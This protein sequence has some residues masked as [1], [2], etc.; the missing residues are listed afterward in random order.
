MDNY[1]VY[2]NN[3]IVAEFLNHKGL[4]IEVKWVASSAT[5][6]LSAAKSAI[7]QGAIVISNPLAGVRNAESPVFSSPLTPPPPNRNI[8]QSVSSINPYL[9]ILVSPQLDTVDFSSVKRIDDAMT[10]YKKNARLRFLAHN[11]DVIKAFQT[12]D[13]EIIVATL[14][15]LAQAPQ[16]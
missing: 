11:D 14:A 15:H 6:V 9:S 3:S 5:E 7:R 12:S 8:P 2:T 10:I 13:L 16:A 4:P 1:I